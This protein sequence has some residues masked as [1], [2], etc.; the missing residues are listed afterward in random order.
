LDICE[1]SKSFDTKVKVKHL[2]TTDYRDT[3]TRMQAFSCNRTEFTL[4][5]LWLVEHHSVFTLGS[6]GD[7]RHLRNKTTNINIVKSDRGGHITYHGPGQLIVYTL[8]NLRQLNISIRDFIRGLERSVIDL[9]HTYGITASGSIN[10]PGVYVEGAKIASLGLRIKNGCCYHGLS[11][12]I[13]MDL[14]PFDSI[15]PCGIVG[16]PVTQM[17]SLGI[18]NDKE[19]IGKN[20][21]QNIL[22]F[23]YD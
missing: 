23:L 19:R 20:L 12:N 3:L 6:S 7:V 18:P 14:S 15:N 9:L 4:D 1:F 8:I 10:N 2:G 11:L 13:S 5:E 21:V 17:T 16:L 22:S